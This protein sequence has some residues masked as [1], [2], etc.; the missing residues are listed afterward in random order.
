MNPLATCTAYDV[1][2][3]GALAP[4]QQE[5]GAPTWK[6]SGCSRHFA[7][8]VVL[9]VPGLPAVL[10]LRAAVPLTAVAVLAPVSLLLIAISAELGHQL[11]IRWTGRPRSCSACC[12]GAAPAPGRRRQP[13]PPPA[14]RPLAP[15]PR[16]PPLAS[17]LASRTL[18][19]RTLEREAA[20][21]PAVAPTPRA[22][23][24]AGAPRGPARRRPGDPGRPGHRLR[25]AA[26]AGPDD[27][28]RAI[29]SRSARPTTTSSTSTRS[30]ISCAPGTPPP[31]WSAE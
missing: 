28:G 23:R 21:D 27:D 29:R 17:S 22:R 14:S 5:A 2:V 8:L 24:G 4:A 12:S 30:G 15:P 19:S 31:G 3:P 16:V 1:P 6:F 11:G 13:L 25:H 18:A 26:G 10:A 9:V 20:A 7:T